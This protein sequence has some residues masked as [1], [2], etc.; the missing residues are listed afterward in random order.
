MKKN[1][2]KIGDLVEL[3]AAGAK[4]D[5][6]VL[7]LGG[8][9]MVMKIDGRGSKYPIICQWPTKDRTNKEHRFKEYELKRLKVNK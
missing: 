4:N 8:Y 6:N 1:K 2:F 7:C 9:D 3:S 5:G